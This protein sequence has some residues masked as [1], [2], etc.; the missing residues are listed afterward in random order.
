MSNG[1]EQVH[2]EK[3]AA[4]M[5]RLTKRSDGSDPT[6]FL[7]RRFESHVYHEERLTSSSMATTTAHD[8]FVRQVL[9]LIL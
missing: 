8:R 7:N 5:F 9:A 2:P 6:A 4:G 3:L 1:Q